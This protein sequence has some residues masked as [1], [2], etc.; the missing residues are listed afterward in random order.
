M[1]SEILDVVPVALETASGVI[2]RHATRVASSSGSLT[3]TAEMSG[4]AAAA[5]VHG[6]FHGYCAA[7]SVRL[8]SASAAL[9]GAARSFTAM[10]DTNRAELA[11]ITPGDM[12]VLGV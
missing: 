11:S 5:A 7:F 8:S 9:V 3:A 6:A 4:V 1:A 2:A 12:P 10:E